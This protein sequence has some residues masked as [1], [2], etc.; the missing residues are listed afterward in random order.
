MSFG[1][2]VSDAFLLTQQA[3]TTIQKSRKACGEHD[4]L[5]REVSALH[6]VFK[7][8]EQEIKKPD[9]PI[10]LALPSDTCKEEL[11]VIT[12]DCGKILRV[13]DKILDK[14]NALSEQ[15][16][17]GRK[18]WQRIKF[19]NGEMANLND[20]RSKMIL[21]TSSITFYLNM[22]SM[23]TIGRIE[24][25]M[26]RSGGVL[27]EIQRAV[28]DIT[29][30]FI[31]RNHYEG[32]VFTN[33]AD[34][35]RSVWREFRRELC[36][37]GFSSMVLKKHKHVILDYIKELGSRGLLDDPDSI[38]TMAE[39]HES[40]SEIKDDTGIDSSDRNSGHAGGRSRSAVENTKVIDEFDQ[41]GRLTTVPIC[42]SLGSEVDRSMSPQKSNDDKAD[43]VAGEQLSE[44]VVLHSRSLEKDHSIQGHGSEDKEKEV[45]VTDQ[46]DRESRDLI[47][48]SLAVGSSSDTSQCSVD[49]ESGPSSSD[50]SFLD[51][52]E[53]SVEYQEVNM[54]QIME[55]VDCREVNM[56][57][58]NH[59]VSQEGLIRQVDRSIHPENMKRV[60]PQENQEKLRP[61]QAEQTQEPET[62]E[63]LDE[64]DEVHLLGEE[65]T[66]QPTGNAK[67][68][69]KER[70]LNPREYKSTASRPAA[71][72][73]TTNQDPQ[74]AAT[75]H[76]ETV[77]RYAAPAPLTSSNVSKII[78]PRYKIHTKF[79]RA[80]N[81]TTST[82]SSGDRELHSLS[83]SRAMKFKK[84][85]KE[86]RRYPKYEN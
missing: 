64:P 67:A 61:S 31:S 56:T 47:L 35:D 63:P 32:S 43:S 58:S 41:Y 65:Q 57:Q 83:S 48:G 85:L 69:P 44:D 22:V 27:R 37:D 73:S 17:S 28:N 45:Y 7:R 74:R 24:Q 77:P 23:G 36:R 21:Y 10:N 19:G 13:L 55:L 68:T 51:S 15:E 49:K 11:Q 84:I 18:L 76:A 75:P 2:S 34:D 53:D 38:E 52:T 78:K 9:S 29:T 26:S 8:L 30:Q 25:E 1:F 20:L 50:A 6:V 54:V 60:E 66:S 3:W 72:R 12:K 46:S 40:E 80:A 42:D 79:S 59:L 33:Y 14:Y 81:Y 4:G 70:L 71:H 16:R 82:G 86:S 39:M 5:T 62:I